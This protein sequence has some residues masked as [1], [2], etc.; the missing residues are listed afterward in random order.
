MLTN[1]VST[2]LLGACV[3]LAGWVSAAGEPVSAL[4]VR[5]DEVLAG[6]R[7]MSEVRIEVVWA[8]PGRHGLV[9]WG[10]GAGVWNQKT[11]FRLKE[12]ELRSVLE[13]LVARGYF[14]MPDKPKPHAEKPSERQPQA[15][16]VLRAIEVRIGDLSKLVSQNN[17]VLTFKPLEGL[18][19]ELF[20][21]CEGPAAAG[22]VAKDLDDGLAKI[23]SGEIAVETLEIVVSEP[24][25]PGKAPNQAEDGLI[26]RLR[27]R[28]V[29]KTVQPTVGELRT[30]RWR[31]SAD[32]IGRIASRVREAGVSSMQGNLYRSRYADVQVVV[33]NQRKNLQARPFA[34]MD[35]AKR[36]AEQAALEQIVQLFLKMGPADAGGAR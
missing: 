13:L 2:G 20:A 26:V 16:Q 19:G 6:T 5:A 28:E 33:L 14:E 36:A 8:Q 29:E 27:E 30:V 34:G 24:P 23:A 1:R 4:R 18:V 25:V 12:Q 9:I 7:P 35:P 31:L 3:L 17:R 22:I 21:L 15:P 32:E 10:S 11:Q